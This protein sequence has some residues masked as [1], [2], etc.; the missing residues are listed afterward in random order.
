[1]E[2]IFI[3]ELNIRKVRHLIDIN[4]PLSRENRKNLILTGKNGSGKT[5]VLKTFAEH[6]EYIVADDFY[7]EAEAEKNLLYFQKLIDENSGTEV[8]LQG[9]KDKFV[10][11]MLIWRHYLTLCKA[12][13]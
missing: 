6:L 12:A 7:T 1:M 8:V 11:R 2:N 10:K 13:V 9:E 4:I 3:T 5:S